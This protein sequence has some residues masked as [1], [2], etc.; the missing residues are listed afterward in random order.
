MQTS[1]ETT[2]PALPFELS[3]RLHAAKL[4]CTVAGNLQRRH[5]QQSFTIDTK[6]SGIDLVTSVDKA[7]DEAISQAIAALFPQ[8][9]LLT[10]ET[11]QED[12]AIL[13]DNTWVIDPIDGTTNYAHGFP[14]FSVSIA[15]VAQGVPQ[16]GVVFDAMRNEMF[17]AVR[18]YGAYMNE[19]RIQ[20]SRVP[21]LSS[22]LLATGFPYDTQ[23]KPEDNMGLFLNFM[24]RCHGVRRA[25][26]A[27][28][29]LAYVACGRLDGF[30]ELRLSPWDVAAGVLLVEEAGGL[31]ADF[32]GAPLTLAQ[33][34]I[35][36]LA[37][38]NQALLDEIVTV[39][40]SPV[41]VSS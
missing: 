19:R 11:Y 10:E 29:D 8:D 27:A 39:C 33:R 3:Q 40:K 28:L 41:G 24:T 22:A 17:W 37:A 25:G 16:I 6:S 12:Q 23:V 7:C 15:Y 13:L 21:A 9:R 1:L 5:Y 14:H 18:G 32:C 36:I 31:T 34:R 26:S 4:A 30:W 2:L 35:D 20:V 38:N